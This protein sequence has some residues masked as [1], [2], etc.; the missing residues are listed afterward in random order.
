M[1]QSEANCHPQAPEKRL[2]LGPTN[3]THV[4]ESAVA[5][6]DLE[7]RPAV[8]RGSSVRKFVGYLR[9]SSHKCFSRLHLAD[10]PFSTV[11]FTA[12]LPSL[13]SARID[14]GLVRKSNLFGGRLIPHTNCNT[15]DEVNIAMQW[16]AFRVR[17]RHEKSVTEQL[18]EKR[19]ECFLP[20]VKKSRKW[21]KRSVVLELPVI[22]GYVFCRSHRFGMLPILKTPGVVDV[23]RTGN[24]PAPIPDWEIS[25]LERAV[26]AAVLIEPCPY[27]EVGQKVEI[28]SGPLAGIVGII[29]DRKKPDHVILSVELL[30]RSVRVQIELAHLSASQELS[31]LAVAH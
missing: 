15:F 19:E 29:S 1:V 2:T 5:L 27:I 30:R 24:S 20:L 10:Q 6:S 14:F 28:R 8:P 22:S 9:F 13:S 31:L 18:R 7:L 23:V 16:F 25:A 26:N 17:A 3:F 11:P 21:A 4:V 12:A